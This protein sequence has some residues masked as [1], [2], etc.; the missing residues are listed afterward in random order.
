MMNREISD[1]PQM[2]QL[3]RWALRFAVSAVV[4]IAAAGLRVW[5]LGALGLR[6]PWL[7]FYPAVM[8]AARRIRDAAI[9]IIALATHALEEERLKISQAGWDQVIGKPFSEVQV[10][11]DN[12]SPGAR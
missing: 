6:I 4:I 7:T 1:L 2:G 8:A 5:P 3:R 10:I 11:L 9:R 12:V